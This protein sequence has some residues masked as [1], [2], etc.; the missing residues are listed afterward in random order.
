MAMLDDE[1][2]IVDA[3]EHHAAAAGMSRDELRDLRID[4]FT[5][6]VLKPDLEQGWRRMLETGVVTSDDS[7]DVGRDYLGVTNYSVARAKLTA[8]GARA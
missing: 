8:D 7:S 5:P 3:S 6:L 4:D 1:R 2:P